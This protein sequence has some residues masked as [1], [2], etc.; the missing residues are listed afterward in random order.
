MAYPVTT[1]HWPKQVTAAIFIVCAFLS[2]NVFSAQQRIP[3]P[4]G[5]NA[6]GY[7]LID[8]NSGEVIA[9][10]NANERMEPASLTKMMASYIIAKALKNGDVNL[11]DKVKISKKAWRMK[12]SRMFIE[13]GKIIQ[14]HQCGSLT[15]L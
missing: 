15:N 10:N 11:T 6:V 2:T 9:K 13:V 4:P 3:E 8:A 1:H 14:F 12:G 7:I 5:I